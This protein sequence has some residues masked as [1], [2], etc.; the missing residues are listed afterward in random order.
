MDNLKWG[1]GD[2]LGPMEVKFVVFAY[3]AG[4]IEG[5]NCFFLTTWKEYESNI[6]QDRLTRVTKTDMP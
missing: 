2:R 5:G 3:L 1:I 4:M 6:V